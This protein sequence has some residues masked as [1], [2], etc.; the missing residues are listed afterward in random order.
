LIVG[1]KEKKTATVAV[2]KRGKGNI[3]VT[4]LSS[5]VKSLQT[6]ITKRK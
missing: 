3:G 4:K 1:E 2:R 5:F 6:E